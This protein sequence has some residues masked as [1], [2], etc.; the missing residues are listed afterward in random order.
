MSVFRKLLG[1][2]LAALLLG[3]ALKVGGDLKAGPEIQGTL[4]PEAVHRE[5]AEEIVDRLDLHYRR[6]KFDDDLSA[7]VLE[8]YLKDLDPN[9]LYFTR[10]DIDD[11]QVYRDQLDDQLGDGELEAGYTIF[12]RFQTRLEAR[13][14]EILA[15]IEAG[16][17]DWS[18][19]GEEDVL[20]DR[21]EAD[22]AADEAALDAIWRRQLK[23][24][25]LSM[26]LNGTEDEAIQER[27]AN[28]YESQLNRVRQNTAEDVFQTYMNA[29]AQSFDPHTNYFTPH[30]S[31][32]FDISMSRSLE[33]I[34]AVLQYEDGYTK[35][36]RLVPGGPAAKHGQL[37][38]AD[39]IVAV[40]QGDDDMVNVIGM[41]LDEVVDMIRG[42][43][44]SEVRLEVIPAGS[45][46]EHDT[47]TIAITRN[48]VVLEEQAAKKEVIEFDHG[49]DTVKLGVIEIPAFYMDF[50][51]FHRGDPNY[52]STTRDVAELLVELRK[53]N[54]DGLVIDLRNNGG[55][56]LLEV[57]KLVSLFINRGPTVQVREAGG[58]VSVEN[59]Q[60]PGMLYAGPMAV[61][62]NR[63]SASASEI[64]AG[65]MQ[66]YGRA[67]IVGDQT[68]GKG[69]VQT[70]LDLNHG[71]LKMTNAKFYRVSGSSNQNLGIV[72]DVNMPSLIDKE[73]VGESSLPN[74]MPWDEIKPADYQR[75]Q[76]L[77]P[78]LPALRERHDER[79]Q[80]DPEFVYVEKLRGLLRRANERHELSLNAERRQAWQHD[81][82][83][84]RL[85]IENTL[86]KHRGEEPI[87]KMED[88]RK[89]EEQRALDPE[90]NEEPMDE[91]PYLR[92]T[93]RILADMVGLLREQRVA[94]NKDS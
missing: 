1:V 44:D 23:N 34:G 63:Y 62:V 71:K 21:G 28:R 74:A 39:R 31:E 32:N 66:D 42:P 53:E 87:D 58:R 94:G 84:Q 86:R 25:V 80:S 75:Y 12:N 6:L 19:D 90:A 52:T 11:F 72:P 2:F 37:K 81:F 48:K 24:A 49:G 16:F 36:V 13:L 91:D 40:A 59:D 18:F 29:L 61:L 43:K 27:L 67:L 10:Q 46:S 60:Y 68:Y 93:G 57:N 73:E 33:G 50:N 8:Q 69:T 45:A 65:A 88:L 76:D 17:D 79:I 22:W 30:N 70:L 89:L 26:R 4:K 47:R 51:A 7:R 14:T 5:A 54:V 55:G 92:E 20:V 77:V 78:L 41:R 85:A 15:D 82:D 56:S 64:F 83:D 9:R 35:V 3:G 38:P